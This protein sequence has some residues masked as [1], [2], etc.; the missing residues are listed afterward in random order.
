MTLIRHEL[1]Q[2]W[3]SLAIWTAAIGAFMTRCL[4]IKYGAPLVSVN[5]SHPLIQELEAELKNE[6]R[7]F[8]FFCAHDVTVYGVLA[9]LGVEEYTLPE[10]M[11]TNTPIGVKLMFERR[12]D[13]EGQ[14]W[15]RVSLIYRSTEQIRSNEMLTLD[16]PPMRYDL[17]FEGVEKNADGLISEKDLFDLFGRSIDAFDRLQDAY[18]L[19]NAA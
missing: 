18:S 9:A 15:Y 11:E 14:A 1:K 5:I 2:S 7:K 12:R 6:G 16:N 10:S 17:S 3:K 13:S 19:A 8:S 4:E